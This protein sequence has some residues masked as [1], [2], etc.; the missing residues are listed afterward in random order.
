M[1]TWADYNIQPDT[2]Y[3]VETKILKR[4]LAEFAGTRMIF[5]T[6][7]LWALGCKEGPH[8]SNYIQYFYTNSAMHRIDPSNVTALVIPYIDRGIIDFVE[9]G[10]ALHDVFP[11]LETL[12][13]SQKSSCAGDSG[14]TDTE[15]NDAAV[16]V[17]FLYFLKTL[18]LKRILFVDSCSTFPRYLTVDLILEAMP[19]KSVC[20]FCFDGAADSELGGVY[21]YRG[22]KTIAVK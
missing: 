10:N 18:S 20:V 9:F 12:S 13:V 14:A 5:E 21:A 11:N 3:D 15:L 22:T 1:S 7:R 17:D 8:T 4:K 2:A 16:A 6:D 19:D